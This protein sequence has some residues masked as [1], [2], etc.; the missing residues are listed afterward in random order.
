MIAESLLI[1]VL[2]LVVWRW[3]LAL[4]H[5]LRREVL[6]RQRA[7]QEAHEA[8]RA[9]SQFLANMSHEIRTPINA[10]QGLLH[11]ARQDQPPP[12]LDDRLRKWNTRRIH[13]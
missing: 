4:G 12:R 1:L 8:N 2:L 7:E 10:I 11:L 6:E 5:R 9:K 3:V 13:C